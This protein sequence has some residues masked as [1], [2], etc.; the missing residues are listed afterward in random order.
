MNVFPDSP[1][2]T[3][4]QHTVGEEYDIASLKVEGEIPVEVE[5]RSSRP[6]PTRRFRLHRG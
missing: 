6:C 2:Y 1:D 3:G 4:P 5:A